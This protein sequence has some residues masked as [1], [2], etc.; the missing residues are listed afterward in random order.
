MYLFI[1]P[2]QVFLSLILRA[3]ARPITILATE[4]VTGSDSEFQ[5][6]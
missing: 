6:I 5:S 4:S 2:L 1:I 3:S